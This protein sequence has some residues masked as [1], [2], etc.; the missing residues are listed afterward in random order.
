[1]TTPI[2]VIHNPEE[3]HCPP[4]EPVTWL[5]RYDSASLMRIEARTWFEVKE[6]AG[7]RLG[8]VDFD[9]SKLDIRIAE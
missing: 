7:T 6:Q 1:M 3:L 5:V 2:T 4:A 8:M 9:L